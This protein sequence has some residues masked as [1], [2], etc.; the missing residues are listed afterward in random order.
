MYVFYLALDTEWDLL[1]VLF[2]LAYV[3]REDAIHFLLNSD[4]SHRES[5]VLHALEKSLTSSGL[6]QGG[7][8]RSGLV[9]QTLYL[10]GS[11]AAF[12]CVLSRDFRLAHHSVSGTGKQIVHRINNGAPHWSRDCSR[13]SS[14][15]LVPVVCLINWSPF[16][17]SACILLLGPPFPVFTVEIGIAVVYARYIK[18]QGV[19]RY[20]TPGTPV[21][22]PESYHSIEGIPGFSRPRSCLFCVTRSQQ[23]RRFPVISGFDLLLEFE[24]PI[25]IGRK[26]LRIPFDASSHLRVTVSC[27]SQVVLHTPVDSMRSSVSSPLWV[28]RLHK[29]VGMPFRIERQWRVQ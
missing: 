9:V 14:E 20:N 17:F 28:V 8:G 4:I 29:G 21:H 1:A 11:L 22:W 25:D 19:V 12:S 23:V 16:R 7:H 13:W 15:H 27:R 3:I 18:L 26:S 6:Q 10:A 2:C 5:G 24:C